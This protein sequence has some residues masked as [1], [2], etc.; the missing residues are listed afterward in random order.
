MYLCTYIHVFKKS[1]FRVEL[2]S[3]VISDIIYCVFHF[4]VALLRF[5]SISHI[6][7]GEKI[8]T[9]NIVS[10]RGKSYFV[11]QIRFWQKAL[12]YWH[13]QNVRDFDEQHLF[14][15]YIMDVFIW[16]YLLLYS[17]DAEIENFYDKRD[18]FNVLIVQYLFIHSNIPTAHA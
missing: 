17:Y 10:G 7:L 15:L 16:Y 12:W 13:H 3:R 2:G 8:D 6:S 5:Y 14:F 4:N 11:K 18:D 1:D 9:N